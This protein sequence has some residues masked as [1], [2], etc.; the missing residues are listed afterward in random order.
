M[1]VETKK[2]RLR[3]LSDLLGTVI[4]GYLKNACKVLQETGELKKIPAYKTWFD[5]LIFVKEKKIY[6]DKK[7]PDGVC[8]RPLRAMT[9]RGERITVTRSDFIK[10]GSEFEFNI[11]ILPNKK[12]LNSEMLDVLFG[13][14][15][16]CGL[17]Q[18][19]ASGG[20]GQFEVV[21]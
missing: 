6:F 2:V 16:Y 21:M 7:E 17:G 8:E 4:K 20:Y 11:E 19:R 1:E 12:G 9:A 10:E 15:K 14:G 5:N 13:Y 3:L 18:W